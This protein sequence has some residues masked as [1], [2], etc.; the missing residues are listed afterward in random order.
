MIFKKR[1]AEN[2]EGR[3]KPG[4]GDRR[5]CCEDCKYLLSVLMPL[6]ENKNFTW[7]K[8]SY[9]SSCASSAKPPPPV[10]SAYNSNI[11][12]EDRQSNVKVLTSK[13]DDNGELGQV[14]CCVFCLSRFSSSVGAPG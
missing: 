7:K 1:R 5:D 12:K 6:D 10:A 2:K 4:D 13:H 9:R 3:W 8:L 11:S 14:S